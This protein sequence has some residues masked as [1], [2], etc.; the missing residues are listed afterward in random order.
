MHAQGTD[1]CSYYNNPCLE[2]VVKV[3]HLIFI[4]GSRTEAN[5]C[6]HLA[7]NGEDLGFLTS[8]HGPGWGTEIV[9]ISHGEKND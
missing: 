4:H 9:L 8:V 7:G 3:A 2:G 5:H 6:G 1:Q